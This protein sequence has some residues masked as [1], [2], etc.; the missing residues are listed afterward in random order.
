[1]VEFDEDSGSTSA[2][3][4]GFGNTLTLNGTSW[5]P[6]IFGSALSFNGSASASGQSQ[7]LV[8]VVPAGDVV[9]RTTITV[10]AWVK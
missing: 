9:P 4:S 1:M 3:S 2:D 7:Q 5:C 6:G 10:A 8:E